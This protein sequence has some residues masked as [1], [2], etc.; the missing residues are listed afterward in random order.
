MALWGR[1]RRNED[2]SGDFDTSHRRRYRVA[3]SGG[4]GLA[5]PFFPCRIFKYSIDSCVRLPVKRSD[6]K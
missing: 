4:N 6:V 3:T 5:L 2:D 1:V